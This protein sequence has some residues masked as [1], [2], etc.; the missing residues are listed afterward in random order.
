MLFDNLFGG[1]GLGAIFTDP[2]FFETSSQADKCNGSEP[3]ENCDGFK[4]ER[5]EYFEDK[6]GFKAEGTNEDGSKWTYTY[7]SND[8]R[9]ANTCCV[10]DDFKDAPEDGCCHEEEQAKEPEKIFGIYARI[11]E[12]RREDYDSLEE[13]LAD[14][15]K[16][17]RATDAIEACTWKNKSDDAPLHKVMCE[18]VEGPFPP[19]H[20]ECLVGESHF[21]EPDEQDRAIERKLDFGDIIDSDTLDRLSGEDAAIL[22]R[23]L[24]KSAV[25]LLRF[26]G[27]VSSSYEH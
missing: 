7:R 18:K 5:I 21:S 9:P 1:L 11:D 19:S 2:K 3:L 27:G 16:Y 24:R 23:V 13:F 6:S 15:E 8:F 25:R 22:F 10:S 17:D 26:F 12:P 20:P 4:C 14:H